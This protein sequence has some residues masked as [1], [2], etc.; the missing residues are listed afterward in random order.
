MNFKTGER[1]V[2]VDSSTGYYG[3]VGLIKHEIYTIEG[4]DNTATD[5]AIIGVILKELKSNSRYGAWRIDRFRKLDYIFVDKLLEE[6]E[7]EELV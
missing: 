2:C 5:D 1:I 6:I 3:H 7:I 4:F